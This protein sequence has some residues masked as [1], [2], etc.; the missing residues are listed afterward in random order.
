MPKRLL[1]IAIIL[2]LGITSL[3][4]VSFAVANFIP[5]EPFSFVYIRST[6][7]V[8]P[9]TPL[10]VASSNDV[11]SLRG[12]FTNTSFVV[13][14][15]GITLD[16]DGYSITGHGTGYGEGVDITDRTNVTIKNLVINQFGAGILMDHASKN[17]LF[18]NKMTTFSAFHM[19]NADGNNI[20][21]NVSTKGY[22]I[23][24]DGSNNCVVNNSFSGVLSGGGNGMGIYL[25]GINNTI[26]RNT[27][28]HGLCMELYCQNSTISYNTVLNGH[29]GILLVRAANNL[30]FGNTVRN[31]TTDSPTI[32]PQA[33]YISD[34]STN[35]YIYENNFENNAIAAYLGGQVVDVVWNNVF[36]NFL[37]RNNFVN[38]TQNVWIAPGTP[39]NHWDNGAQGNYWSNFLGVDLNGDGLSEIPYVITS[40]NTDYHP[41]MTPAD[42]S[43]A[44]PIP[45]SNYATLS[46]SSPHNLSLPTQPPS[47]TPSPT[48]NSTQQPGS[49]S[50]P[51]PSIPEFPW[52]T[53]LTLLLA[54]PIV[55]VIIR[56]TVSRNITLEN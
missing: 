34:T 19:I 21:D 41:L 32:H 22:G 4:V 42:I 17:T 53:I 15:D 14:R 11:Y 46:T 9:A 54:I 27:I 30:V 49:S 8:E 48:S 31:I 43:K 45:L 20:T 35:N 55:L 6:G 44:A 26:S 33:L 23:Y 24:G 25:T 29:Y 47:P 28:I 1:A 36:N 18:G 2:L 16:G 3:S 56:K 38:N 50:T 7:I 5:T 52:L 39:I 13:E 10:I 12:D 40:N 37:F 51:S